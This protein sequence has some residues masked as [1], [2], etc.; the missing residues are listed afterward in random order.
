MR[1][2]NDR[3]RTYRAGRTAKQDV[4][5]DCVLFLYNHPVLNRLFNLDDLHDFIVDLY[6]RISSLVDRYELDEKPLE[7]YLVRMARFHVRTFGKRKRQQF[8]QEQLVNNY[9]RQTFDLREPESSFDSGILGWS[10]RPADRKRVLYL[11]LRSAPNLTLPQM[12]ALSDFSGVDIDTLFSWVDELRNRTVDKQQRKRLA[13][14][15]LDRSYAKLLR[16]QYD[17]TSREN[18]TAIR[19]QTALVREQRKRYLAYDSACTHQAIS[20]VVGVSKGTVD[21]AIYHVKRRIRE[22]LAENNLEDVA[23]RA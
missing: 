2:L 14:G 18:L 9:A 22:Q 17:D 5:D 7:A 16:L 10:W 19:K 23:E 15:K 13:R 20:E 21:S 1:Q 11:A 3:L 8:R 12:K 6:P 4:V